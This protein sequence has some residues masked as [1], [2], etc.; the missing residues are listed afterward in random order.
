MCSPT[1]KPFRV[2]PSLSNMTSR[3]RQGLHTLHTEFSY[4]I[5][6]HTRE[7]ICFN[8][9]HEF[10]CLDSSQT[11]ARGSVDY[12]QPPNGTRSN[13]CHSEWRIQAP[14]CMYEVIT[15]TQKWWPYTLDKHTIRAY[16]KC[17]NWICDHSQNFALN[18]DEFKSRLQVL[19]AK[20]DPDYQPKNVFN[21]DFCFS[22]P[23]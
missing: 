18:I 10:S 15:T 6:K 4:V 11:E 22:A 5:L 20:Y 8:N 19:S 12:E 16:I 23:A 17:N 7:L 14:Q 9:S 3:F 21:H 13:K 1:T 2:L